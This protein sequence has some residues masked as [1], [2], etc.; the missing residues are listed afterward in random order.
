MARA[1]TITMTAYRSR[2]VLPAGLIA[3][4]LILVAAV[5]NAAFAD[6]V[7]YFVNGKA[8]MVKSVEKGP[9]FSVLEV[10]GGGKIGIPNEQIDRIEE[11]QVQPAGAG[12]PQALSVPVVVTPG[13]APTAAPI[14]PTA[15]PGGTPGIP[16]AQGQLLP[17]AQLPGVIPGRPASPLP[18]GPGFGG[19][20]DTNPQANIGSLNPIALGGNPSAPAPSRGQP[21]PARYMGGPGG[22]G[23]GRMMNPGGPGRPGFPQ[24]AMAGRL[25]GRVATGHLRI[26][27]MTGY[28]ALTQAPPPAQNAQPAA[29]PAPPPPQEQAE[30]GETTPEPPPAAAPPDDGAPSGDDGSADQGSS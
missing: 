20:A 30:E 12:I 24:G 23:G 26:P 18:S 11:Y 21:G 27:D 15:L 3:G 7:V 29:T 22:V 9:K 28:Q 14:V 5:P 17:G 10:E 16:V 19:R 8:M 25:P 6:Q 4:M 13:I 2:A 1:E